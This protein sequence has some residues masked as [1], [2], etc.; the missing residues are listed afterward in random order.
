MIEGLNI[1]EKRITKQQEVDYIRL[2]EQDGEWSKQLSRKTKH[3]GF[4]YIYR[5]RTLIS[6]PAPPQWLRDL[7]VELGLDHCDQIIINK[8]EPG[9]GISSHIDHP[10]L[11]GE[12]IYVLSLGENTHYKMKRQRRLIQVDINRRSL[13]HMSGEARYQWTHELEMSKLK[14]TNVRIGITWREV[15]KSTI[16]SEDTIAK[17][18][19][20][21]D[22]ITQDTILA[23][24]M[25]VKV[26]RDKNARNFIECFA[27][28][29]LAVDPSFIMSGAPLKTFNF[30]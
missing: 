25:T 29:G 19:T 27:E 21:K 9:Q 5:S 20:A 15:I 3:Y 13:L 1:T 24:N 23:K 12:N 4:E 8:Y 17:D 28:T 16:K 22:T 18:S 11:F 30:E 26:A 2:I 10:K 7:S 14:G 6:A